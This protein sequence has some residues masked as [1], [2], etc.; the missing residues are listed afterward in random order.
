VKGTRSLQNIQVSLVESVL[1][2]FGVRHRRMVISEASVKL[3]PAYVPKHREAW[4]E[5]IRCTGFEAIH[6]RARL[7]I[8]LGVVS[9]RQVTHFAMIGLACSGSLFWYW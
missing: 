9:L 1:S 7:K 8:A 2:G 5:G 3:Q 4:S 6:V